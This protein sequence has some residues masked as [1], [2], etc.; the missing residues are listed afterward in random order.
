MLRY[1]RQI[2]TREASHAMSFVAVAKK[3]TCRSLIPRSETSG[4]RRRSEPDP[5]SRP[6]WFC[7][8]S[9]WPLRC[10]LPPATV[11]H[12]VKRTSLTTS[13]AGTYGGIAETCD[14]TDR[15]TAGTRW[16]GAA[17]WLVLLL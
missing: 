15:G 11:K 6:A 4:Q 7:G 17:P 10:A 2:E 5:V 14:M 8:L 13:A 3:G 1:P 12:A 16:A 9:L